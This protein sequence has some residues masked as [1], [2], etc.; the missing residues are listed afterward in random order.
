MKEK[1][2]DEIFEK[3]GY[4]KRETGFVLSYYIP[5][6]YNRIYFYK[7]LYNRNDISKGITSN[8]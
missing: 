7:K 2:A 5:G 8:K 4:K 3:I 1:T 6:N